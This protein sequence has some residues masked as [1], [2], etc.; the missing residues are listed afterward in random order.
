MIRKI[1]DDERRPSRQLAACIVKGLQITP[2]EQT[3]WEDFLRQ[4]G[5]TSLLRI[6]AMRPDHNMPAAPDPFIG[7]E[8]ELATI[9]NLLQDAHCRLVTLTGI[10]GVG[11]TD[12][13]LRAGWEVLPCFEDGV[14]WVSL[15]DITS[16]EMIIPAIADALQL[17]LF[18]MRSSLRSLLINHLRSRNLLLIL[19]NFDARLTDFSFITEIFSSAPGLKLLITSSERLKLSHEHVFY[20]Y[21][22]A[23]TSEAQSPAMQLFIHHARRHRSAFDPMLESKNIQRLCHLVEGL[24]L[25]IT[26]AA[27]LVNRYSLETIIELIEEDQT[28]LHSIVRDRPERHWGISHVINRSWQRLTGHQQEALMR[29]SVCQGGFTADAAAAIAWCNVESLESLV[30]CSLLSVSPGKHQRFAMHEMI[31]QFAFEHLVAHDWEEETR[32]RQLQYFTIH[33]EVLETGLNSQ[34]QVKCL[35]SLNCDFDNVR[36]ALEWSLSNRERNELGLRLATAIYWGWMSGRITEGTVWF[37]KSIALYPDNG[38]LHLRARVNFTAGGLAWFQ[39]NNRRADALI[40]EAVALARQTDDLAL[41]CLTIGAQVWMLRTL[42]DSRGAYSLA[43]ESVPLLETLSPH[44]TWAGVMLMCVLC[45]HALQ[46]SDLQMAR[47]WR[48]KFH[49]YFQQEL[50][51]W[52]QGWIHWLDGRLAFHQKMFDRATA[53][54]EAAVRTQTN[55]QDRTL[56][57]YFSQFLADSL[58]AQGHNEKARNI[59]QES[60]N[61]N[62]N[63]GNRLGAVYAYY[64]LVQIAIHEGDTETAL[65]ITINGLQSAIDEMFDAGMVIYLV[66]LANLR[67]VLD[68]VQTIIVCKV[69]IREYAPHMRSVFSL[70]C[71]DPEALLDEYSRLVPTSIFGQAQHL[72]DNM[73]LLEAAQIGLM[74]TKTSKYDTD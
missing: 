49:P 62:L 11:K 16:P 33:C 10:G 51:P 21:G 43:L 7:R 28:R 26:L 22:L 60:L 35:D 42:G 61:A 25:A 47:H 9:L 45:D 18:E 31:R 20:L 52:M 23:E 12:L 5:N 15:E 38:S 29:L 19:D 74:A 32:D 50:S 41:L 70:Y 54:F 48:E 71:P 34:L 57:A 1:E 8:H 64:N 68:W 73:P 55:L 30:D 46:N 63:I 2:S 6:P 58:L 24:P 67:T 14:W 17:P 69:A 66:A 53:H 65:S 40:S 4:L 27:S 56:V 3:Y 37:E 59:F 13:A 72:A 39:G 44:K 36:A